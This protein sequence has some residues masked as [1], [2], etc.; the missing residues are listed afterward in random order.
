MEEMMKSGKLLGLFGGVT[1]STVLL[2]AYGAFA[3]LSTIGVHAQSQYAALCGNEPTCTPDNSAP[4]YAGAAEARGRLLNARG[5]SNP[6]VPKVPLRA[7][8]ASPNTTTPPITIL[9]GSTSYN[10][11]APILRLPGRMTLALN[12]F[13]NSRL[14]DV[15]TVNGTITFNA[16]RD[17]PS[18]GFRLDFGF[19]EIDP[20]GAY[21]LTEGDGAKRVLLQGGD[22]ML[23]SIDGAHLKFNPQ[24]N[25]LTYHNG[26]TVQYQPFPS[27]PS[28][29]RPVS[30]KDA[31]GNFFSIS[32]VSGHDQMIYQIDDTMGRVITFNYDSSNRLTSLTQSLHGGG[33]KTLVS[34]TWGSPYASGYSWYNFS[35]LTVNGAPTASQ[36]SVLTGCTYPNGTGYRFTYGDWGIIEEIETLGSSGTTRS[37]IQYNYPLA[38]AGA[39]SDAPAYTQQTISPDGTTANSSSWTYAVTKNGPGVVTRMD[40]TD[41]LG[42]ISTTNLDPNTGLTSSTQI[43]DNSGNLL[44]QADYKWAMIGAA[45]QSTVLST[46]VTTLKD[47]G[48][49]S[50]VAYGYDPWG[51]VTDAYEYDFGL[52][53]KRHTVV[54]YLI[55]GNY[56][57][58]N[59]SNLPTQILVKDGTGSTVTRTDLAYDGGNLTSVTGAPGHDD[60]NFGAGFTTRG[61]VTSSTRYSSAAAGAG[62]FTQNFTYDTLGNNLTAQV[63]SYNLKTFNFSSATQWSFPDSVVRGPSSGPQFTSN[64]TYDPDT[65][66]LASST[67][68]NGQ[69]TT[70]S[71]DSMGRLLQTTLPPQNGT[72]VQLT[73]AFD[74]GAALPS[75]I[76]SSTVN[77]LATVTT[78]DGLG[79]VLRVDNENCPSQPTA[80]TL[81]SSVTTSYDKLWRPTQTSNPFAPSDTPVNTSFGYDGLGRIVQ[82]TPP[83]A[84]YTTYSYSGN[85]VTIT[86]PASQLRRS[87]SDALGRLIEVDEPGETFAGVQASGNTGV[88]GTLQSKSNV[89]ASNGSAGTGS[90]NI[91]GAENSVYIPG[92]RY[93]NMWNENGD[94]VDWEINPGSTVYDAG[95]VTITVNGHGDSYTYGQNDT[96]SSIAL[97]LAN[98]INADSAAPVNASASG[99]QVFLTAK[100][101]GT[102]TN[103]S[104]ASTYSYDTGDFSGPS[105]TTSKS[106]STLTG[107][108]NGSNGTTV[109]DSGTVTITLG[110]F[111]SGSPTITGA[112]RS[113]LVS[114]RYCAMWNN[115]GQCVDWESE[116]DTVY[117]EGTVTITV[118]GHADSTTYRQGNDINSVAAGLA[119]AINNDNAAFVNAA[120]GANGALTLT[121][122]LQGTAGDY[123]WSVSSASNDSH[124][125]GASGSFS[126]TPASGTLG[127]ISGGA[128]TVSTPYSQSGNS[129][130]AQLA[131][132]LA[133]GLNAT[134]SPVAATASGS[135]IAITYRSV[136]AAGNIPA[137]CA[138]STSQGQYFSSP[139]F[140]CNTISLAGGADA[141]STGLAHPYV[142]T[143]T[144]DVLNNLTGV[145]QA[146][147]N[148]QGQPVAGQPR[149]YVYDSIGRLLSATTPESGT[150]TNY[151]TTSTGGTCAGDPSLPCRVQDARGLVKTVSYDGINRPAGVTYSDGTPSVTS[152]YDFGGAAAFALGRMTK[153][154]EGSNSQTLTYDNLG[155]IKSVSHLIDGNSYLLQYT[156]NLG[157]QVTA[158]TY[159]TGRV[160][161]QNVDGIGRLSSISDGTTYLNGLAY[162][163]ASQIVGMT[164]GNGVNGAFTYNDHLQISTLRYFKSGSPTD[165]LNLAY[166]YGTGNSGQIQAVHYYTAPGTEDLTKSEKFTYDPWSRL[167]AAQTNQVDGTPGTWNL[168]WAYDRLGNRLSQTLVGGNVTINQ[169]NFMINSATN[170]I[171]NGGYSYDAAGNLTS[172]SVNTFAY[173]GANRLTKINGGPPTYTY[174]GPLRIKKV[175]GSTTTVYI[176][177]TNKPIAEYVNGS[178]TPAREYIYSGSRLLATITGTSITYYHPD[179]LSNRAETDANGNVVR[180][181]ANFPF[182]ESWYGDTSEKWRFTSYERDSG[183]GETGLDYAQF[184]HYASTQGRFMSVDK[185]P[186]NLAFPQSL[187]RYAYVQSDPVNRTDP[188]GLECVWDD[189]SFD[190]EDDPETGGVGACQEAGGTWVELGMGGDWSSSGN[191]QLATLLQQLRDGVIKGIVVTKSDG[192]IYAN[193]YDNLGRVIV[194]IVPGLLTGYTYDEWDDKGQAPTEGWHLDPDG[195]IAKWAKNQSEQHPGP[196][197][198]SYDYELWLG[199]TQIS[200]EAGMIDD[201]RFIACWYTGSAF[202]GSLG[203]GGAYTFQTLGLSGE[204]AAGEA[205]AGEAAADGVGEKMLGALGK[206][207]LQAGAGLITGACGLG[208]IK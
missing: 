113:K 151:Y 90:V 31:N 29:L 121:A 122:R 152:Q 102:A 188:Q 143:Y 93:C 46:V 103:Y 91:A 139:S 13:Y 132:A 149:S 32:Y 115:R 114:T 180:T 60:T 21:I 83:S 17:F 67:D 124:D 198:N 70:Y 130:A 54:S 99:S 41:P 163:A 98:R 80:C 88:S 179:H 137:T 197:T 101:T 156:Y 30:L 161:A 57:T 22:V 207:G 38:S 77:N 87:V 43:S 129:T 28:L 15:D 162:N 96:P 204:A 58:I 23:Y 164:L 206:R 126:A 18:Y 68:E 107:G 25:I 66:L 186:G 6:L 86:D 27:N 125:F 16:D 200:E 187:N 184:R 73:T 167:S 140:N 78:L 12:L 138:S 133:S 35:G 14:W 118:N 119:Q 142:T 24:T 182:G 175:A 59:L 208:G 8:A 56:A 51:N 75:V 191:D 195:S 120:A 37:Y 202:F 65:G 64:F 116:S 33:T 76:N 110:G 97:G 20:S 48:Q 85:A 177:S 176:Y 9:P 92:D 159:P 36:I 193:Y 81:L 181:L 196:P 39:L 141:Y 201:P 69:V 194:T 7:T 169:P 146:A 11:S 145:S 79:H 2:C 49:Q 105:F 1:R 185:L 71:H 147:G 199:A 171:A 45:P 172:D 111:A 144:Y 148:V 89:G 131:S 173:D 74:D 5:P 136:G 106:G 62:A 47:T 154:T 100:T 168:Q 192:R 63:S 109:Y 150:E 155:R 134:G 205:A 61:L 72:A 34:F 104:L 112:E 160:V 84:G 158:I 166:D 55:T 53:L 123:S 95:T 170:R 82:V 10:W 190:S 94:C 44:R 128:L 157:G 26:L 165:V 19:V 117:D 178:L 52:T 40:I 127:G 42:G 153:V 183:V 174:F 189:G 50:K 135:S 3:A 4:P 108:T 203:A